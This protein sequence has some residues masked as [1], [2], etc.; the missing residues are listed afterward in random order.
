MRAFPR[1]Q[2]VLDD[3]IQQLLGRKYDISFQKSIYVYLVKNGKAPERT[4]LGGLWWNETRYWFN[5]DPYQYVKNRDK[6]APSL[7]IDR[8]GIAKVF[9]FIYDSSD[10]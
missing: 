8:L 4:D 9:K 5:D 3:Q 6:S 2:A 1:I 7:D 10:D